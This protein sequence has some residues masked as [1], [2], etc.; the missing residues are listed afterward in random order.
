V[1]PEAQRRNEWRYKLHELIDAGQG[2]C[3]LRI[4]AVADMVQDILL[5]FHEK[6]YY[7]HAWV[8]MPNHFH[9]LS[10]PVNEWSMAKIVSSWKKYTARRIRDYLLNNEAESGAGGSPRR[11]EV[12]TKQPKINMEEGISNADLENVIPNMAGYPE[13]DTVDYIHN[14]P[15]KA[16]LIRSPEAWPWSSTGRVECGE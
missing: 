12:L 11:E 2:S 6:R 16:G 1:L 3:L 14:N 13:A 10:E 5:F 4:P 15:V 8:V 9:V 7:L